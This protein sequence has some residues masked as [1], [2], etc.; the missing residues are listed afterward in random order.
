MTTA[1]DLEVVAVACERLASAATD[2]LKHATLPGWMQHRLSHIS[3]EA[4][5]LQE[6]I[7]SNH[8]QGKEAK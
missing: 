7:S 4:R 2:A 1:Y 6:L 5:S 8:H 3:G